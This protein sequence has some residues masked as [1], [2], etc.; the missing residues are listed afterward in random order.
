MDHMNILNFQTRLLGCT[1]GSLRPTG[2][3][4]QPFLRVNADFFYCNRSFHGHAV[5]RTEYGEN[6]GILHQQQQYD[7]KTDRE[8]PFPADLIAN[9]L[10]VQLQNGEASV[11][12]DKVRTHTH[13]LTCCLTTLCVYMLCV[14][15]G[16][17][18]Q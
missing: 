7:L 11:A 18:P 14:C 2:V 5:D 13:M 17:H 6:G 8:K 1:M 9:A 10:K 3:P 4:Q 15:P 12:S 16:A